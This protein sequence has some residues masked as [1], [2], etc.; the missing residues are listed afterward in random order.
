M[1]QILFWALGRWKQQKIIELLTS[2]VYVLMKENKICITIQ[3]DDR[4]LGNRK[5]CD[6]NEVRGWSDGLRRKGG[7]VDGVVKEKF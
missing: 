5:C 4:I 2:G 7:I 3:I 1:C 6:K